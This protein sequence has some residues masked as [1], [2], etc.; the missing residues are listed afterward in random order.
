MFSFFSL[1]AASND[2][3][4]GRGYRPTTGGQL[5]TAGGGPPA[6]CGKSR[7]PPTAE[8]QLLLGN[9]WLLSVNGQRPLVTRLGLLVD[10]GRVRHLSI[11]SGQQRSP[12]PP[13]RAIPFHSIEATEAPGL[14]L[15]SPVPC[16]L[17]G[18]G[19][20]LLIRPPEIERPPTP[21]PS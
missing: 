13:P 3:P 21:D 14:G 19:W 9:R 11:Y 5:P 7:L 1:S 10:C 18:G 17:F 2:R 16:P 15:G 4:L 20:S 6:A 12:P 8:S